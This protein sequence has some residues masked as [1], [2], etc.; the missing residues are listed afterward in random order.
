MSTHCWLSPMSRSVYGYSGL[1]DLK[2]PP[3]EGR[4]LGRRTRVAG[5]GCSQSPNA[6][7]QDMFDAPDREELVHAAVDSTAMSRWS[8]RRRPARDQRRYLQPG[9]M[10]G[11]PGTLRCRSASFTS[12]ACDTRFGSLNTMDRT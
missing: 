12:P 7:L 2:T 3:R 11:P 9:R 5:P 6:L 1:W 4:W 10:T 8:R